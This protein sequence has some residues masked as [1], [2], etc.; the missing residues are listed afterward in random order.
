MS[1]RN[2]QLRSLSRALT[3]ATVCDGVPALGSTPIL[4]SACASH[5]ADGPVCSN[6]EGLDAQVC[7]SDCGKAHCGGGMVGAA[8][9]ESSGCECIDACLSVRQAR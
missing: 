1:V 7:L 3:A 8:V 9:A 5:V 4:A 6:A 2:G